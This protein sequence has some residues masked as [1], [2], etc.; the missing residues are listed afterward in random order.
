[1]I[2]SRKLVYELS[3]EFDRVGDIQHM[4]LS[5]LLHSTQDS[6]MAHWLY[7]IGRGIDNTPVEPT[8]APKGYGQEKRQN[9]VNREDKLKLL[10]WLTSKLL[11]RMQDDEQDYA[12]R[13]EIL[14]LKWVSG[15]RSSQEW[16][17][18]SRRCNLPDLSNRL[19]ADAHKVLY[20]LALNLL[21][22]NIPDNMALR[23]LG[24]SV[25]KFISLNP[26][27][28]KRVAT[29]ID[30]FFSVVPDSVTTSETMRSCSSSSSG[31]IESYFK[32][33]DSSTISAQPCRQP[34]DL[35]ESAATTECAPVALQDLHST[36]AF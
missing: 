13:P 19:Q 10:N 6:D 34:L 3:F 11:D 14:I 18:Q 16:A 21:T 28:E 9:V 15:D 1:M 2:F 32:S 20:S 24:L 8:G 26:Q 7:N 17:A 5:E 4:S 22:K 31:S 35:C 29:S 27:P 30:S 25:T 36:G 12:R 23:C 33:R